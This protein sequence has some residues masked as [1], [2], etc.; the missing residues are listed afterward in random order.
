MGRSADE[1]VE[2][3]VQSQAREHLSFWQLLR[4]YLD[5]FALFKNVT[6]GTRWARAQALS[7]NRRQR[8]ILLTYVRRWAVIALASALSVGPLSALAATQPVLLVPILGLE[9]AFTLSVCAASL[10]LAVYFVLGVAREP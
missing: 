2:A 5:P 1:D 6:V 7:Y 10:S 4:L 3:L 8:G 9:L